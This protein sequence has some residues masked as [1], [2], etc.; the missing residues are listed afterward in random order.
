MEEQKNE[1]LLLQRW[2][3]HYQDK[4]TLDEFKNHLKQSQNVLLIE[5][6]DVTEIL[7]DLQAVFG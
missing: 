1:E 2:L 5:D 3:L 4:M 7:S 6:K